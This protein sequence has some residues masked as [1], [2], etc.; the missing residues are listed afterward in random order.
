M[1]VSYK[2]IEQLGEEL[3]SD[4]VPPIPLVIERNKKVTSSTG[5]LKIYLEKSPL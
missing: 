2:M 5:C 3:V 4:T 1:A